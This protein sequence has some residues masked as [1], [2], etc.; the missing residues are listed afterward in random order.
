MNRITPKTV[1][2]SIVLFL[3]TYVARAEIVIEPLGLYR[4][5]LSTDAGK[6]GA[7]LDAGLEFNRY[8]TG[9]LRLTTFEDWGGRAIDEA[10]LLVE[11][12]LL[13]S[14]NSKVTLSAIGGVARNFNA[15]SWGLTVGPRLSYALSKNAAL[16]TEAQLGLFQR[17]TFTVTPAVALRLSF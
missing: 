10:A 13:R 6:W 16:V 9:H 14:A 11:G 12:A 2:L 8:V 1:L 5:N 4:H 7:G 15:G 17:D 3:A